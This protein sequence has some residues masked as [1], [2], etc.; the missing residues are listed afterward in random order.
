[1]IAFPKKQFPW[2]A[3]WAALRRTMRLG[4]I[5]MAT[6][7]EAR[8]IT[9][10]TT[11]NIS[12]VAGEISLLQAL[13]QLRDGDTVDFNIPGAGPHF[14]LTPPD[15][16]PLITNNNITIDGYTQPG[17][18]PNANS[19]LAPNNAKLRIVLD[20]RSGNGTSLN[21]EPGNDG[22]GY[23]DTEFAVLG[24]FRGENF[25]LH[26]VSILGKVPAEGDNPLYGIAFARDYQGT[27]AGGHVSGC[28]LGVAP[29]G[30]TVS[31]SKYG[32]VALHH[33]DAQKLN[34]VGIDHLTIGV[35]V[36]AANPAAEFNVLV[37]FALP[38][39][40]EGDGARICGNFIGVLPDGLHDYNV[41][42]DTNYVGEF[43][44]AGSIDIGRHGNNTVIGVD[45]DG[46]NDAFE[47]NVIGGALPSAMNGYDHIIEFYGIQISSQIVI[48]G[49]YIG[50]GIDGKTQ[51]TNGVQVINGAG[52]N[53]TYRIGSNFDGLSDALEGNLIANNFPASVFPASALAARSEL[54]HFFDELSPTSRVLFRGNSL[55]NN[56][57][58]PASPSGEGRQFMS[59]YYGSFLASTSQGVF[60]KLSTNTTSSRLIGSFPVATS[61]VSVVVIDLYQVDEV[62]RTN[63]IAAKIPELPNGFVQ[64]FRYLGSFTDGATNDFNPAPCQFDFDLSGVDLAG[65]TN[66]TITVT[67]SSLNPGNHAAA[68]ITSPF[69][70]PVTIRSA[71]VGG[72]AQPI[73][74]TRVSVANGHVQLAWTGG[75]GPFTVQRKTSF[76]DDW[77]SVAVTAA[78]D[79]NADLPADTAS[80]FFRIA[81]Q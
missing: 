59:D 48:A 13:G 69:S 9:V 14:I 27:A 66:L 45:G 61:D 70:D 32:I 37:Q 4:F 53:A 43:Q 11:N 71:V 63:G 19:I 76:A 65:A 47:R 42:L 16:Y 5:V 31:G 68:G 73:V 8:T 1:M 77:E 60:P 36:N 44:F 55:I 72:P 24:I 58:F 34:A 46:V 40:I 39:D 25:H 41:A 74:F 33:R 17:A 56:F 20:S 79:R 28:W 35:G 81:G 67:Y 22:A 3:F 80:A 64:G 57:P 26:G 51:F 6:A 15:G 2:P 62:G 38:I 10:S 78:S 18:V 75:R 7:A 23:G 49:N 50:I 21:Y 29:D 54:L 52:E 30:T 12:P